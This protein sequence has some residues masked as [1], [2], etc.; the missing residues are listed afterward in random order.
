VGPALSSPSQAL[1][2][3]DLE[4]IQRA[5]QEKGARWEAG[6]NPIFRLSSEQPKKPCGAILRI[7][8]EVQNHRSVSVKPRK[9]LP[10]RFDWRDVDGINW[11]TPIGNQENCGSCVAFGSIATLEGCIQITRN[12][13]G[14]GL[15]LSEQHLFSCAGGLCDFGLYEDEALAYLQVSGAPV[16]WCLPYRATDSNCD[17]TCSDWQEQ[18]WLISDWGHTP[19]QPTTDLVERIKSQL[20]E[21]PIIAGM[22]VYDDFVSYDSGVYQHVW[23]DEYEGHCVCMVGWDDA[24]SCWICK[25]S[26]GATWGEDGYFRIRMGH[27]EVE[28]E[29]YIFWLIPDRPRAYVQIAEYEIIDSLTGDGD[30]TADP[31]ETFDLT[32]TLNN[33]ETYDSLK[34]IITWLISNDP[35][36]A[37]VLSSMSFFPDLPDGD[38]SANLNNPYSIRLPEQIG[39]NPVSLNLMINGTG[40]E[41]GPY[42]REIFFEIPVTVSQPGWPVTTTTDVRGCPLMVW[43]FGGPRRLLATE[44]GGILHMWEADGREIPNYTLD[45]GGQIWG[46]VAMGDLTGDGREE[47]VFGSTNDTL[48]ALNNNGDLLFKRDMDAD[49]LSTPAIS[50]LDGDGTPEIVVGTMDSVLHVLTSLGQDKVPFPTGLAGPII[51]DVALAD[52]NAD[53]HRDVMVGTQNGH[54]YAI[55]TQ[56]GQALEGFPLTTAGAICSGPVVA[57]MDE[58]GS[59]EA[60]FGCDDK[61]LYVVNSNGTVL[62]SYR[63]N[64]A[65]R[66][67]PAL[68]DIDGEGHLDVLFTTQ[69]GGVYAVTPQGYAVSGWPY[70]TEK[71]LRSSPAVVDIDGDGAL[72]AIVLVPGTSLIHLNSDGSLDLSIPIDGGDAGPS[73]PVVGDLDNDG[74]LEVAVGAT[75][76]VHVY[77]YPTASTVDI[78][79]PMYRGCAQRTG[80]IDDILTGRPEDHDARSSVPHRLALSQNYPNPFNPETIIR[81]SLGQACDVRLVIYNVLGQKVAIVVDGHRSAGNHEVVWKGIDLRG[82]PVSSGLYFYRLQSGEF[83]ETRKM[84]LLR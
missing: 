54:F 1:N 78:A 5:I 6:D 11:I 64:G 27:N 33:Y 4:Q 63:S 24:D 23:G 65:I 15:D 68:A 13:P 32:L 47:F 70:Q 75:D 72:E 34:D 50:D 83:S 61:N 51:A 38:T 40:E 82:H 17:Q 79:W 58:N 12:R 9:E 57:D 55:C 59:L 44:A 14:S 20:M 76:G 10:E 16:E 77:D 26:W 62:W 37:E 42:Y 84:I 18:A 45:V 49:I 29:Y 3:S 41:S 7:T 56:T 43:N 28:I 2:N 36:R 21:G 66:C 80:Y 52:L 22:R 73:S 69:G 8:E 71:V 35:D 30:G 53:G 39:M 31:G 81:Y 19:Y 48:Y 74:D 46:S 25:N 67:S 60:V